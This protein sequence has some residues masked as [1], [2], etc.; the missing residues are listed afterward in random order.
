[1]PVKY[2]R[3]TTFFKKVVAR[4]LGWSRSSA[5]AFGAKGTGFDSWLRQ[6]IFMFAF[7]V[8]L[9]FFLTLFVENPLIVMTFCNLLCNVVFI[10]FT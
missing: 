8:L 3:K 9:W 6:G 4:K 7:F 1:M 5:L 10:W 2:Y